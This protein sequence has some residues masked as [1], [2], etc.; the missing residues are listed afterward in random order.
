VSALL[1]EASRVAALLLMANRATA[2]GASDGE[3]ARLIGVPVATL[4]DW[5]GQLARAEDRQLRRER[6]SHKSTIPSL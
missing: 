2:R 5:R 3:A 1:T 4:L 6:F